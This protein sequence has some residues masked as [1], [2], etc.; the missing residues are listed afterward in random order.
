MQNSPSSGSNSEIQAKTNDRDSVKLMTSHHPTHQ[1]APPA[2]TTGDIPSPAVLAAP[3]TAA[4]AAATGL[5]TTVSSSLPPTSPS[6]STLTNGT[7][8]KRRE[9]PKR[10]SSRNV[11]YDLKKRKIIPSFD[12]TKVAP[13]TSLQHTSTS[14][15]A[16]NT[17][18][19]NNTI[20]NGSSSSSTSG[21]GVEADSDHLSNVK[22]QRKM[23]EKDRKGNIIHFNEPTITSE[24]I[25]LATGVP[26]NQGPNEKIKRFSLWNYKRTPVPGQLAP[27]MTGTELQIPNNK[28]KSKS[29]S[30]QLN[31]PDAVQTAIPSDYNDIIEKELR[32]Y[33]MNLKTNESNYLTKPSNLR[34]SI[35]K[36]VT[37]SEDEERH[38]QEEQLLLSPS[39]KLHKIKA[40]FSN[41]SKI[42]LLG[43]NS[44]P[45]N[46][47][48]T[49]NEIE[50][51]KDSSK[52]QE[53]EQQK[54]EQENDDY[55][56]ACL[57][58]G[59]FL[60]CDTC[61]R[62]FHFLCLDPPLDP[63]NLPE[64]DWSCHH[65]LFKLK[66]S[67]TT[68]LN[69]GES[70]FIK[71]LSSS[72]ASSSNILSTTA[73]SS[74]KSG[75]LFGKLLFQLNSINPRQFN[76]PQSVKET[77]KNVKTGPRGQYIDGTEKDPLTDKQM[78]HPTYGQSVT[79]LDTYNPDSHLDTTMASVMT[80][81]DNDL[82]P[83]NFLICYRCKTTKMGTW[84]H[85]ENSR[86][87]MK[88]DYCNTPWHLDCIPQV[89]RASL[90]N[91]GY[92]WKC[93]LH[94]LSSSPSSSFADRKEQKKRRL[95]RN[96][97]YIEPLQSSG[98][99]ND[100]DIEIILD[101]INEQPTKY[102]QELSKKPGNLDPIPTLKEDSIKVDFYDKIFRVRRN[103]SILNFK[104]QNYILDRL[105]SLSLNS[106]SSLEETENQ[107]TNNLSLN[108]LTSLVFFQFINS[109]QNRDLRTLWNFKEL[110]NIAE[111]TFSEETNEEP[112][113]YEQVVKKEEIIS[114]DL[115]YN[116]IGRLE[117]D[118]TNISS[119]ELHE[120]LVLRKLVESK[121]KEEVLRFFNLN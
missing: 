2:A 76:L 95:T 44:I 69:K 108:D 55:C 27:T 63:N 47:N 78:F 59:S 113:A 66:Y 53:A 30:P 67:N 13:T 22:E 92:K 68:Q 99:K 109:N 112:K 20:S 79:K 1:S 87:I 77:F 32:L 86:L 48:N 72:L 43:Q 35:N 61:P 62:S 4:A 57:Q 3:A 97:K 17:I 41:D 33:N 18:N 7:F 40:T 25:N 28:S 34:A 50:K 105:I 101:E 116:N 56:S 94:A 85:P 100:G 117:A 118:A 80:S 89:P 42:K 16:K 10:S 64:G 9:R 58:A 65:C 36:Q 26:L 75:R 39:K 102:Y 5:N 107:T 21:S 14:I 88:C 115:T 70:S 38:T 111:K 93:P 120:L 12:S 49:Q 29:S 37:M 83:D 71:E 11:D 121:P 8:S 84:D 15:F 82:H 19:E 24:I 23:L 81:P 96:Q 114:K 110:C 103:Q 52:K 98:F 60:C 45:N 73:S 74:K 104:H 54:A 46:N 51:G 90:K 91:L 106:V 31:I 119:K 6:S